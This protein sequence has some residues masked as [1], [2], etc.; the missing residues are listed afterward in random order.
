MHVECVCTIRDYRIQTVFGGVFWG[1]FFWGE[2]GGE[3]K[4]RMSQL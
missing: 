2:R 3:K 4:E 1:F